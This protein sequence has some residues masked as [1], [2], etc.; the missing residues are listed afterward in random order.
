MDRNTKQVEQYLERVSAPMCSFGAHRQRLRQQVLAAIG[1]R[2]VASGRGGI[3]RIA[4]VIA[5][6]GTGAA[7][8]AVGMKMQQYHV[9]GKVPGQG[10]VTQS[11]DGQDTITIS[12]GPQTTGEQAAEYAQELALLKQQGRRELVGAVEL[13]VNGQHDGRVLSYEYHL[14]DGQ[15]RQMGERDPDDSGPGTLL[16]EP[17]DRLRPALSKARIVA[18]YD[19][20]VQG[21]PFSFKARQLN[22]SD[23]R[24]VLWAEG[25]PKERK[26]LPGLADEG[27][28]RL[29]LSLD[30]PNL[31][32]PALQVAVFN[33]DPLLEFMQRLERNRG[34]RAALVNAAPT[35][36]RDQ[37]RGTQISVIWDLAFRKITGDE[38]YLL[39]PAPQGSLQLSAN[40]PAGKKGIATK[41]VMI[42]QRPCCWCLP[43]QTKGGKEIPL[44]LNGENVLDL[45][46]VYD[47]IVNRP[48][49]PPQ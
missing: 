40:T 6:L 5:L 9:V 10:Y 35:Q 39:T 46:G 23:G 2:Q 7:A 12:A 21:R 44:M 43:V 20:T 22:L 29:E 41:V 1:S 17:F 45:A 4:A 24:Q 47:N 15:T 13:A 25:T 28:W 14:S 27:L 36:Q 48:P 32:A 16:A 11:Q 18:T 8:A 49:D 34:T 38:V 3:R 26:K 42:D 33:E 19:R 30:M 31:T 37:V